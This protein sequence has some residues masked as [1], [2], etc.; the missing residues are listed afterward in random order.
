MV[1]S[2]ENTIRVPVRTG[3]PRRF[4][5]GSRDS[6]SIAS[7]L[8]DRCPYTRTDLFPVAARLTRASAS[9]VPTM[10]TQVTTTIDSPARGSDV[11]GT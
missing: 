1:M 4:I 11:A 3:Y 5:H 10:P 8:L 7:F 2:I 9:R 6:D